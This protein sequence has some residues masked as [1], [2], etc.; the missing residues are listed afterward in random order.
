MDRP[1]H[2][3]AVNIGRGFVQLRAGDEFTFITRVPRTQPYNVVLR[4]EV[5][6]M[7]GSFLPNPNIFS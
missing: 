4:Y 5:G 2:G 7:L 3:D 1:A 6:E